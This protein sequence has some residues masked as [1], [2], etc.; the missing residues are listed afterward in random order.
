MNDPSDI[1]QGPAT[2]ETERLV[3]RPFVLGDA[4]AFL[5]M[6]SEPEIIRAARG[7]C[8]AVA[9]AAVSH[10]ELTPHMGCP[11]MELYERIESVDFKDEKDVVTV[12][13]HRSEEAILERLRV[14]FP[15]D[16]YLAE[17]SGESGEDAERLW[18]IDPLDGTTN[19]IHGFPVFAVSIGLAVDGELAM[20]TTGSYAFPAS[21]KI[22]DLSDPTRPVLV[23]STFAPGTSRC[24]TRRRT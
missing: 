8:R 5:R 17:E 7:A 3:L 6:N 19:F 10:N 9:G 13:D 2:L 20:V 16:A 1:H 23:S 24:T 18:V 11:P 21:F 4:E 22:V 15:D 12:A 14:A